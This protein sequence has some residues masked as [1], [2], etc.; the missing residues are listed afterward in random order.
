MK[1]IT[2]SFG[3][4]ERERLQIE[5]VGYSNRSRIEPRRLDGGRTGGGAAGGVAQ[6][7]ARLF[8]FLTVNLALGDLYAEL[9]LS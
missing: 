6:S 2:I 8:H 1:P 5:V 4:S 7:M 9:W 3:G